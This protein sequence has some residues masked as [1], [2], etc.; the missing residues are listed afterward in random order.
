MPNCLP[1]KTVSSLPLGVRFMPLSICHGST[2]CNIADQ[3]SN[4]TPSEKSVVVLSSL[5]FDADPLWEV[6]ILI[7]APFQSCRNHQ[8]HFFIIREIFSCNWFWIDEVLQRA[9]CFDFLDPLQCEPEILRHCANICSELHDPALKFRLA[10]EFLQMHL[11]GEMTRN[12]HATLSASP[13]TRGVVGHK[14]KTISVVWTFFVLLLLKSKVKALFAMV[15]RSHCSQFLL[16]SESPMM[17]PNCLNHRVIH[18]DFVEHVDNQK[19]FPG[20]LIVSCISQHSSFAAGLSLTRGNKGL[21]R[22]VGIVITD[23]WVGIIEDFWVFN[24]FQSFL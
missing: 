20:I 4:L 2:L 14:H 3:I 24:I 22:N 1:L 15:L 12:C 17:S 8:I 16:L 23:R 19:T 11:R 18:Q 5:L 21:M 13:N 9:G 10:R 6:R 7:V